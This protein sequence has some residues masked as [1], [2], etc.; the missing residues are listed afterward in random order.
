VYYI[1][2]QCEVKVYREDLIWID[3]QSREVTFVVRV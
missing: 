1:V 2:F 3:V